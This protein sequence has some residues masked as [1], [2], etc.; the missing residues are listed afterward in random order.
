MLKIGNKASVFGGTMIIAGTAIG[1]GMLALP[2]ISAG[3]WLWW[4]L[5]L[6][7]V[8]WIL[9]LFSSQAI[10]EVNLKYEP[11]AS[12]HTIVKDNL[13]KFWNLVNGLSVAFVLYILLYAYVSGGG[14]MV[15]H[16][17][18]SIF[19]YEPPKFISGLL[20]VLLLTAC[21]WWSTYVVDRISAVLIGGMV[22]TFVFAMSGMIGEIRL[23]L[24]LDSSN[25]SGGYGIFVFVALS[26]YLTSFC[27]HASVPS[28][29][30]YFGKDLKSINKCLVYGTFIALVSYIVWIIA[31]DGNILRD[32]FK[33]V[34]ANGGNVSNLIS[35]ASSGLNGVFLIR[36]LE[37]FAFLAVATSFLGAGLGLFD[38]MADLCGFDDSRLGRTKTMLV[39]F[40]PPIIAG[41]IYP[42]GFLLAIGWAGLA[43]TIWS[44]IIPALLLKASRAR[45]SKQERV[46]PG[47]SFSIY[48]LLFF[49]I[50]VGMCHILFVFE[51]LPMYK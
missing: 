48:F 42:D 34:I 41:M 21:V 23:P 13:G 14:S 38:Y 3:M 12:F 5:G 9:M 35:V 11:G 36:M 33:E 6:L 43:A 26:T 29:V 49:G 1:A 30:K 40:L 45:D 51:L 16:T 20:F 19:G 22:L 28:L 32:D 2:T 50:V 46:L 7:Y 15:V 4:S 25:D 24:L 39:T 18:S 44:V 17:T 37:S 31:C 10:L 27:F 47:G 8:T